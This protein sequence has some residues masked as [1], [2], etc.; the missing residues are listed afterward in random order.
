M[1][2]AAA[3]A[4]ASAAL[5]FGVALVSRRISRAP[6]SSDQRWFSVV[7]FASA[8][9]SLCNLG[10]TLALSPPTVLWL[11][12]LQVASVMLNLWGWIRYSSAFLRRGERRSDRIA[13]AILLALAAFSLVPGTV[14]R[15]VFVDRPYPALGVVYR[16]ALTTPVGDALMGLLVVAALLLLVRACRMR[17]WSSRRSA[18]SWCSA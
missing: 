9:Y 1:N 8:A 13:G 11:S 10:T 4:I 14:F 17:A 12:R 5:S 15:D 7:A 6:G 2:L 3:T 18:R 16:Q